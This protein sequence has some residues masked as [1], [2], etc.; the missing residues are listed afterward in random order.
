MTTKYT[1]EVEVAD[2]AMEK[3]LQIAAEP[4]LTEERDKLQLWA[5]IATAGTGISVYTVYKTEE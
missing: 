2:G 5:E 1:I 3:W 4:D